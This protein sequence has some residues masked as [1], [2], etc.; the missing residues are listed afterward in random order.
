MNSYAATLASLHPDG[1]YVAKVDADQL[2]FCVV[3]GGLVTPET[4][5][6]GPND[7]V[8]SR[9]ESLRTLLSLEP[10]SIYAGEDITIEGGSQFFDPASAVQGARKPVVMRAASA[11]ISLMPF[12]VLGVVMLV[13]VGGVLVW[14]K[15]QASQAQKE[16]SAE[17]RQQLIQQY[18]VAV[19]GALANYPTDPAW[20]Q[21]AW[22]A[23]MNQLPPFLAGYR[24]D[25]VLCV[26]S[27][28]DGTYV[29]S[30]DLIAYAV[31]PFTDRFGVGAVTMDAQ[32]NEL[33]VHLV[34]NNATITV[35]ETLLHSPPAK[36]D[37]QLLDWLG[38]TP[39][40]VVG[41]K[42]RPTMLVADLAAANGGNQVGY[43]PFVTESVDIKGQSPMVTA[44]PALADWAAHASFRITQLQFKTPYG[45]GLDAIGTWDIAVLRFHG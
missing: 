34:L 18:H 1:L 7:E 32:G 9:I 13:V 12:V 24:L 41:I 42:D 26:P 4:D 31:S 37:V 27:G 2:W 3:S 6:I 35:D 5:V 14:K 30:Q 10:S 45:G 25:T 38:R 11:G 23:V 19:Q 15:H 39:L 16:M 22:Q 17:Q 8:L 21:P 28:C 44:L 33:K 29:R 43:P 20:V 36:N 40:H